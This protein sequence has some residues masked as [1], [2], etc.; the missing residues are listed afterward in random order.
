MGR[1]ALTRQAKRWIDGYERAGW[2]YNPVIPG[3]RTELIVGDV[4]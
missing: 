1:G 2:L 3:E 4:V